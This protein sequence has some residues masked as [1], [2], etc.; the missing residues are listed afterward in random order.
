MIWASIT[1]F[2]F[3]LA[4]LLF[5]GIN[6]FLL[7]LDC[8]IL[9]LNCLILLLDSLILLLDFLSLLLDHV[10]HRIGVQNP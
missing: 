5:H 7:L 3:L 4:Q 1:I 10:L 2:R 8:L 6:F 9:L